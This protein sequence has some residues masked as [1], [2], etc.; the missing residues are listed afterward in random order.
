MSDPPACRWHAFTTRP[1]SP[2][3]TMPLLQQC[4]GVGHPGQVQ[5]TPGNRTA[6]GASQQQGLGATR[7]GAEAS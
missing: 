4:C 5:R 2:T 1:W 3:R 6:A 7:P